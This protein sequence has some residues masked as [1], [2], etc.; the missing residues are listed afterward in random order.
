MLSKVGMDLGGE[1]ASPR[2]GG[3]SVRARGSS[4]KGSKMREIS[5]LGSNTESKSPSGEIFKGEEEEEEEEDDDDEDSV[6]EE[7]RL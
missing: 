4:R 1:G 3:I 2:G 7:R 5:T 6:V